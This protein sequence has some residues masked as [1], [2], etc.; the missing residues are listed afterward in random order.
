VRAERPNADL[1]IQFLTPKSVAVEQ[2]GIPGQPHV[3]YEMDH[4][5]QMMRAI[6]GAYG[7][8][9]AR[10]VSIAPTEW[11]GLGEVRDNALYLEKPPT[12][13]RVPSR[14]IHGLVGGTRYRWSL[15]CKKE[16]Y[17]VY[18]ATAWAVELELLDKDAKVVAQ[19]TTP[20]GHPHPLRLGA[21]LS[22]LP[23]HDWTETVQ[24]F[25]APANAV[26]CRAT[27]YAVGGA[28]YFQLGKLWL[29]AIELQ[30]VGKPQRTTA[31]QFVTLVMPLAKGAPAPKITSGKDGHALVAHGNGEVDEISAAEGTLTLLRRQ[32][33]RV[34]ASITTKPKSGAGVLA[35]LQTNPEANAQRVA[36]GLQPVLD[37][38]T[39]ER[40]KYKHRTNLARGARVTASATRDDRFPPAKVVDQQTAEYPTDGHLDYTLG[41]VWSSGRFVGYGSGKESLLA[42]R[43]YWPLYIKPTYWLLPEQTL[44]HVELELRRPATVDLVRLLN[45]SNAGLNDFATHTFRVELYDKD[46]KLL[47]KQ[48]GAFG[49]VFDR[50]FAQAFV[51]PK[52]FDHYTP[53]FAGMLE[54]TLTVPFG[55]GWK[56]MPFD[57]VAGVVF[58]R[59]VITK[60]WGIGGG[61]NE[62]QIYGK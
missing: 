47:G 54:P 26:A 45:T 10:S 1:W 34:V 48:D 36:A 13:K 50:P 32:G 16:N 9:R 60:Y 46:H 51:V 7:S 53:S 6:A 62:I 22:N 18:E 49:K 41:I 11:A 21:P 58:V 56:E 14:I 44:G 4:N 42:N 15:K 35:A 8:A 19:P 23:T 12:E 55:D 52:W 43:D 27:Y 39:A 20:Y 17:R 59:V 40:D 24:Y 38:I 25:D 2:H 57:Q 31:Q 61:L 28:H 3:S 33:D 37:Q 29:G 30:P 5:V